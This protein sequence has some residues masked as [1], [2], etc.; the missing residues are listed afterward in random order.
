M[1]LALEN[2]EDETLEILGFRCC[3]EMGPLLIEQRSQLVK[4]VSLAS[5]DHLYSALPRLCR[6][7]TQC[8]PCFL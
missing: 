8:I 1:L 7:L 3:T 6:D 2:K 5:W 4:S